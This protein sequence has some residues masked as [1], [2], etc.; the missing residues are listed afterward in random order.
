MRGDT[1]SSKENDKEARRQG[2]RRHIAALVVFSTMIQT[3][4]LVLFSLG[5]NV[6]MTVVGL[7]F[8]SAVGSASLIYLVFRFG[9]NQRFKNKNLLIPQLIIAAAIQVAFLLIAPQLAVIFLVVLIVLSAYAVVEFSPRQFTIGWLIYGVVTAIALWLIR[10][11]FSYPGTSGLDIAALW[12]FCFLTLRSLT[13]PTARFAALRNKLSEKNRQLEESL[14]Q[15]EALAR[16]DSLTGV[17]NHRSVI[18]LLESELQR[19]ARTSQ[20]F[21]FVMVDLD[22]FKSVNDRYGHPAGDMVLKRV[23]DIAA[24]SLRATD[25][26]GRLGGEEFA[27]ILTGTTLDEGLHTIERLRQAVAAY[28]WESVAPGLAVTFSAGVAEYV[29]A[30]SV[31]AINKR[32]DEALYRAKGAGRNR[33]VAA[34]SA[35]REPQPACKVSSI[36]L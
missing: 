23:C 34:E 25:V 17:L 8:V 3:A 31:Q 2:H 16:H 5:G 9:W 10:D 35:V 29:P 21:C 30:D 22:H 32:A 36:E 13:W 28:D 4:E 11:R 6:S 26:I 1:P 15:I 33:V 27:V 12:L 19:S 24:G 18:A 20:P 14:R 7:F